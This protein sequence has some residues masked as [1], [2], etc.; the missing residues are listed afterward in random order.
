[1][2][3][4]AAWSEPGLPWRAFGLSSIDGIPGAAATV[5][6][7]LVCVSVTTDEDVVDQFRQRDR[8]LSPLAGEEAIEVGA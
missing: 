2:A 1:V 5:V 8:H 3:T 7:S 4:I 6:T